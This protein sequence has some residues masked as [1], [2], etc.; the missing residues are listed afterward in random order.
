MRNRLMFQ[1]D[2]ATAR[3]ARNRTLEMTAGLLQA[4]AVFT[5]GRNA[6][7]VGEILD[8]LLLTDQ[9]NR[10]EIARL[11]GMAKR[12]QKPIVSLTLAEF[13]FSPAFIPRPLLPL[14]EVPFRVINTFMPR[15]VRGL[16]VRYRLVPAR[17]AD[18]ANP[19]KERPITELRNDR[20]SSIADTTNLLNTNPDLN[21][22]EMVF[23][24]P[25]LGTNSVLDLLRILAVR[26]FRHQD[27]IERSPF[28][29]T[30]PE[31]V[32]GSY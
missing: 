5:P 18:I 32:S 30:V 7:P 17:N 22:R 3:A 8:H 25:V 14:F 1:Q 28:S 20:E 4:Q 9:T 2:L 10:R 23:D 27:Q 26:E 12:G 11:V 6:C 15:S 13:N 21:Y 31:L 19:R 24:H 16:I 29:V